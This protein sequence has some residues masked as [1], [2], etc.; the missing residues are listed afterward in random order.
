MQYKAQDVCGCLSLNG[1]TGLLSRCSVVVS[2]DTGPLHLAR[3]VGTATVGIYWCGNLITAGAMTRKFHYPAISWRLNCPVCDVDCT[4]SRCEHTA[5]FVD[6][7]STQEVT[8]SALDLLQS[9]IQQIGQYES[10]AVR[11]S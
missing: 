8:A 9:S 2:N 6:D 4:R 3:A 1:L 5:S 11:S 7:V 10:L